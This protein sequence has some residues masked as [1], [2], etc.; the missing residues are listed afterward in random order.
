MVLHTVGDF[1]AVCTLHCC[2]VRVNIN[3]RNKHSNK[4]K[5]VTSMNE[6]IFLEMHNMFDFGP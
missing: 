2:V 4:L 6:K 5:A 3:D 1:L